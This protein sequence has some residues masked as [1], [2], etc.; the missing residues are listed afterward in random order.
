MSEF[1]ACKDCKHFHVGMYTYLCSAPQIAV[2]SVDPIDGKTMATCQ[3][4]EKMRKSAD[5]CG[6]EGKWFEPY[7]YVLPKMEIASP[8]LKTIVMMAP[9]LGFTALGFPL[10]AFHHPW[11]LAA[12]AISVLPATFVIM[13]MMHERDDPP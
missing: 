9:L 2:K 11:L 3:Y 6:P 7:P 4:P 13:A 1:P 8:G 12:L 10:A 5:K